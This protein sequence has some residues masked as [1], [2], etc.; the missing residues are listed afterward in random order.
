[1]A[2]SNRGKNQPS[3][4]VEELIQQKAWEMY[5]CLCQCASMTGKSHEHIRDTAFERAAEF[6][7]A[8]RSRGGA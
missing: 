1:M 4:S 6:V 8:C 5:L 7:K 3:E 2:S